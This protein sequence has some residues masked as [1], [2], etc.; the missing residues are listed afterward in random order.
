MLE[1]TCLLDRSAKCETYNDTGSHWRSEEKQRTSR[2]IVPFSSLPFSFLP[3]PLFFSPSSS[4]S[5]SSSSS[6]FLSFFFPP[7]LSLLC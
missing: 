2:V 1:G 3:F 4:F 7:L 5:S 6:P